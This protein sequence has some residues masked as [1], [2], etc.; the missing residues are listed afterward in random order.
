MNTKAKGNRAGPGGEVETVPS[1]PA[2]L[3][4]WRLL[5]RPDRLSTD[6]G[7]AIVPRRESP[8]LRLVKSEAPEPKSTRA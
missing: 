6:G 1:E 8:R 2:W 4:V 7:N 3:E 5:L